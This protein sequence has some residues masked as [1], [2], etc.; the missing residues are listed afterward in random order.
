[1]GEQ[2]GVN[3]GFDRRMKSSQAVKLFGMEYAAIG[4]KAEKLAIFAGSRW[5]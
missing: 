1:L 2:T 3:Y 5:R 4:L